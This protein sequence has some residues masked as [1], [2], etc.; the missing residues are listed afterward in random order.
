MRITKKPNNSCGVGNLTWLIMA[1]SGD[2]NRFEE[3]MSLWNFK[4]GKCWRLEWLSPTFT[5]NHKPK[6]ELCKLENPLDDIRDTFSNH[7]RQYEKDHLGYWIYNEEKLFY[8][9]FRWR[10]EAEICKIMNAVDEVDG[11]GECPTWARIGGAYGDHPKWKPGV[12]PEDIR[13]GI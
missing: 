13:A 9:S 10:N 2:A 11:I 3:D 7:E 4:R 1:T 8:F 12:K 6:P 5:I